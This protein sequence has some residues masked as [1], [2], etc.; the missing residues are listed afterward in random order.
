[1]TAR[2]VRASAPG[3]LIVAGEYAVLHGHPAVVVAIDRRVVATRGA[4]AAGSPFLAAVA[5]AIADE[6]GAGSAAARAARDLAV[7]S[8]ALGQDGVKLGLGS[9]A[10]VTV[11]ATALALADDAG[12]LDLAAV[13]RL[14]HRAHG[15][16]QAALAV[17]ARGSGLDVA[18]AVHGGVL[19]ATPLDDA[20]PRTASLVVPA[21]LTLVPVWTGRP[22]DTRTLVAAVAAFAA[23]DPRAHAAR[24]ADLA[25]VATALVAACD[26]GDAAAV[27]AALA[28]GAAALEALAAAS[29]AALVL[30]AHRAI[31]ALAERTGGTAKPTG[32]GGGDIAL[33]A[34]ADPLAARRFRLEA[35]ALGMKLLDLAVDPAGARI[36]G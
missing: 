3:K 34:F 2:A 1:V 30:P 7:D 24:V 23:R 5:R 21:A 27:V 17:T 22:A 31:A 18:A 20:P 11:A 9:S 6:R 36:D 26:R 33:A 14:A 19:V 10:A 15:D 28:Q 12:P 25:A 29:G 4:A 16:A 35:T 13:H 8:R 32:A